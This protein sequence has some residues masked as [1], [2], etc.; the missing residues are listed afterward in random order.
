M[1]DRRFRRKTRKPR[2]LLGGCEKPVGYEDLWCTLHH[3]GGWAVQQ[4]QR[5]EAFFASINKLSYEVGQT[6]RERAR[7]A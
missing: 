7:E 4:V 3:A 6:I 1:V 5:R 2:C